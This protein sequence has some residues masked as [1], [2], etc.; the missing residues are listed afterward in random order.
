MKFGKDLIRIVDISDPEWG[1]Y[2]INYKLM[3]RKIKEIVEGQGGRRMIECDPHE[4]LKS[5]REVEF[6]RLLNSELRKT[7][8]FFA[9]AQ[10][11]CRIRHQRVRDGYE[12]LKKQRN[13]SSFSI[14]NLRVGR[15]RLPSRTLKFHGD[16]T[17]PVA[18]RLGLQQF[19]L[20]FFS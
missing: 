19:L 4:I 11:S 8:S 12:L 14:R 1:P 5:A 10:D 13:Y 9:C 20:F 2:W 15:I 6:F 7:S 17:Q 3:K 18:V 16:R